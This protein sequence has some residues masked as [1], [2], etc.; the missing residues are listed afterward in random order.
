MDIKTFKNKLILAK[1]KFKKNIQL[2][3]LYN[4]KQNKFSSLKTKHISFIEEMT[5]HKGAF[6]GIVCKVL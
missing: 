6:N 2:T 3:R 1:I 5:R 4:L